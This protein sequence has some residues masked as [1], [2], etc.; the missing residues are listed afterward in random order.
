MLARWNRFNQR[1]PSSALTPFTPSL[2][3][4]ADFDNLF[5]DFASWGLT[6][7]ASTLAPAADIVETEKDIQ[8]KIDLPGHSVK[9]IQVEL[10]GDTLTV[11]SERKSEKEEKGET[12]LRTERSYGTFSR[13][14]VLPSSVDGSKPEA[15]YV[16]GVLTITLPKRET[17]RPRV[18]EVK[19]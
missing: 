14:F 18:I 9:D 6:P 3:L 11:K 16:D 15:R 4:G 8:L 13:S 17:A 2:G 7:L 19:A 5:D 1:G 10:E 12:Y